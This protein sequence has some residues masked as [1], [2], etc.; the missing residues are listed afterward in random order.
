[1]EEQAII[2]SYFMLL[3]LLLDFIVGWGI[4]RALRRAGFGGSLSFIPIA[5]PIAYAAASTAIFFGY[6][7]AVEALAF[8][9]VFKLAGAIVALRFGHGRWP[10]AEKAGTIPA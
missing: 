2:A 9:L 3:L 4:F 7:T 8:F 5:V 6:L 10:S 1:M